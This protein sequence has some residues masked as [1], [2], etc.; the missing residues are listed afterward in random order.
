MMTMTSWDDDDAAG[1]RQYRT[2]GCMHSYL[3]LS[4]PPPPPLHTAPALHTLNTE[5]VKAGTDA[6]KC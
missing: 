4:E 2:L 1:C 5:W 6:I 3:F